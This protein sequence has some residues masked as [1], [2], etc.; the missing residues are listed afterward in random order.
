MEIGNYKDAYKDL[1][2]ALKLE[3]H[4]PA[5][6]NN[7]GLLMSNIGDLS[8]SKRL[9][10]QALQTNWRYAP[11]HSNKGH[12]SYNEG[13]YNQAE[14]DFSRAISVEPENPSLW[15]NRALCQYEQ[16]KYGECLSD[17]GK[18]L[19]RG[20]I[21]NWQIQYMTGMCRARL[22]EYST[23]VTL[24]KGIVLNN[25][26]DPETLSMIWN[27]IGVIYHRNNNLRTAHQC[28]ST[29]LYFNVFNE[30]AVENS[31]IVEA[32]MS[33]NDLRATVEGRVDIGT[34]VSARSTVI[35]DTEIMDALQIAGNIASLVAIPLA[36]AL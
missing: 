5:I 20:H 9:F 7:L 11:P 16:G 10:N 29:A 31:D 4:E 14:I 22:Q 21:L 19:E 33:G 18:S 3:P 30:Q 25:G 27:N 8:A 12:L 32:T 13:D 2:V 15:F 26:A 24:L 6:L 35:Q 28:F 36:I 23:S 1:Q 34:E 17:I